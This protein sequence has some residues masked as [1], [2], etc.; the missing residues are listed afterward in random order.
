M[1]HS[2]K[3]RYIMAFLL[4]TTSVLV[5]VAMNVCMGTVHISLGDIMASIGGRQM[6]NGRI[7]W[8]IRM[9]RTMAA[10][11][12]GGA[13]A[14]AGYLLQTFFHN[15]IAGPFVLG[16]SSGAKMVVALVMVFLMGQ[17]V[18]VSSLTLIVAAFL[19]AMLS[20]GFVL[21]MSRKVHNMSMLVVS[22]VMIGYIC[23]AVTELVVTFANDAEIVNLHNW[24]RGSF[25]G[26]TWDNVLVMTVVIVITFVI[27][28]FMAKPLDAY[29][30][31]E[32]Y[33]QNMGVNIR[34]LRVAL[35]ILSSIF[36]AC[37]VAFAGPISFVGVA[38][39]HLVKSLLG[40]TK[41]ILMIPACFLGGS[42]FCLFCDLLARTMLA[43]T[44]L[45]ISTVTAVFGAPV[46]LWIMIRRSRE[47]VR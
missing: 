17:A 33:A 22:G 42:V 4:L 25:S 21:L 44:E 24:S 39:P 45:S 12:L 43:P 10:M 11:I 3:I 1:Q 26:M 36:S 29:Q 35:V 41:P 2:R 15:P 8:D 19:G 34:L 18:R 27:V 5:F 40:S 30:L 13:L 37:I 32:A 20:M 23:S 47:K 31:G 7:L 46:V 16:I 9:P 28:F 14:L 6:N 38:V